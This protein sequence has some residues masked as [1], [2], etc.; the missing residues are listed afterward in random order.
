MTVCPPILNSPALL[1]I[2]HIV[3][4][5]PQPPEA[6]WL[7]EMGFV[8]SGSTL[9][10]PE[11]GTSSQVVFFEN[12]Y[13]EFV[14][15]RSVA[16]ASR[17]AARSG[18]DFVSRSNW[19]ST[20]ASPFGIGVRQKPDWEDTEA[21]Q[22]EDCDLDNLQVGFSGENLA[23]QSEPLCFVVPDA[24]ALTSLMDQNREMHWRLT[25]H[26]LGMRQLTQAQIRISSP[27][28]FSQPISLLSEEGVLEVEVAS[29]PGLALTFDQGMQQKKI[30]LN[31]I[32]IPLILKF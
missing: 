18:I 22:S 32:E 28:P 16:A 2:D 17:Y 12:F 19:R 21:V 29:S 11:R 20:N 31:Q 1:E 6:S 25:A 4:C 5:V 3:V 7:Q 27:M 30:D 13:L 10:Y 15:V 8:F 24:I 23:F 14:W 9:F 26:P